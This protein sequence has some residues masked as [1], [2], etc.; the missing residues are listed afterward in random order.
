MVHH[1]L[2]MQTL[3]LLQKKNILDKQNEFQTTLIN[4]D[5]AI[6]NFNN[7][8]SLQSRNSEITELNNKLNEVQQK[9]TELKNLD[10]STNADDIFNIKDKTVKN[11]EFEEAVFE[12]DTAITEINTADSTQRGSKINELSKFAP[13]SSHKSLSVR[14]SLHSLLPAYPNK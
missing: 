14:S 3:Y 11:A 10:T 6:N 13:P 8:N 12:V 1:I 4:L 7:A 9:K 5:T 2:I